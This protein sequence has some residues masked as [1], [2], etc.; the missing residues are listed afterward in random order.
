MQTERKFSYSFI[1]YPAAQWGF[2]KAVFDLF[3]LIGGRAELELTETEFERF[4]SDLSHYGI[5]LH[6]VTR[7][8]YHEP[9]LI[10]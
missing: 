6:E 2:S 8:P 4:K 7:V 1:A 5:V 3:Q 10:I 9:E